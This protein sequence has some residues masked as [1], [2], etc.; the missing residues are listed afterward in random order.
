[1]AS[2]SACSLVSSRRPS[3]CPVDVLVGEVGCPVGG[4]VGGAVGC[5]V[6][7]PVGGEVGFP[8][9]GPVGGEVGT[10]RG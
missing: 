5:P 4:P 2:C 6:G 3:T 10:P 9:D 8:V 7:G 1:M